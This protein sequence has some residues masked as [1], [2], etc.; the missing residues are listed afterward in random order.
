MTVALLFITHGEIGNAM[1]ES[2]TTTWGGKLPLPVRSLA[3][4][5][6]DDPDDSFQLAMQLVEELSP[7]DGILIYTDLFGS[8]PAKISQRLVT[9]EKF[10]LLSGC[11]LPSLLK[12]LT[13]A[14]ADL[15]TLTQ[16]AL[17]GGRSG[18]VSLA[19]LNASE[20]PYD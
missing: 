18:L 1:V 5:P 4:H 20:C 2:A 14:E 6:D 10:D 17:D 13:H 11:N 15:A 12:I 19:Q 3:I 7:N 16:L 8:T 9:S